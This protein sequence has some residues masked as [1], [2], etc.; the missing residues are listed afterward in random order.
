MS[1]FK[2]ILLSL[3]VVIAVV[4]LLRKRRK[5]AEDGEESV[6]EPEEC[7]PHCGAGVETGFLEC[8]KCGRK[9][10]DSGESAGESKRSKTGL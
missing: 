7:C 5:P 2:I 3:V 4:Q 1:G 6:P 8:W 10:D 9:F